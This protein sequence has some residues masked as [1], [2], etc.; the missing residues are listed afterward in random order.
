MPR[1]VCLL[2]L[3]L[4]VRLSA[5]AGGVAIVSFFPQLAVGD[6]RTLVTISVEVRDSTGRLVPDNTQVILSTTGGTISES[7]VTTRNGIARGTLLAP[8]RAGMVRVTASIPSE[9]TSVALDYEFVATAKEL[10]QLQDYVVVTSAGKLLYASQARLMLASGSGRQGRVKFRNVE[11]QADDLQYNVATSEVKA[12]NALLRVSGKEAEFPE[13]SYQLQRKTGYGLAKVE[14]LRP[15]WTGGWPGKFQI[16]RREALAIVEIN[17]SAYAE[18]KTAVSPRVFELEDVVGLGIDVRSQGATVW[19]NRQI[20]FQKAEITL[21]GKRIF[22][23]PLLKMGTLPNSPPLGEQVISVTNSNLALNYP[24]Y[25]SLKPDSM[26]MLRARSGFRSTTGTGATGGNFLD[27]EHRWNKG[28]QSDGVLLVRGLMRGDW[29]ATIQQFLRL[30]EKTTL[31]ALM[32]APAHASL[33]NNLQLSHQLPAASAYYNLSQSRTLRGVRFSTITHQWGLDQIP[34]VI[35]GSPFSFSLGLSGF[36]QDQRSS[37]GPS[38]SSHLGVRARFYSSSI[39]VTKT[40][41]ASTS[42]MVTHRLARHQTQGTAVQFNGSLYQPFRSGGLQLGYTF[43]DDPLSGF[44]VGRHSLYG[45]VNVAQGRTVAGLSGGKSLDA[46]RYNLTAHLGY[47]LG[48]AWQFSAMH[49]L[50]RYQSSYFGETSLVLSKSVQGI[51]LGVS[52]SSRTR[53]LG[54]EFLGAGL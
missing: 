15:R 30:S 31:N 10:N 14:R 1:F 3:T 4:A 50:D 41:S 49:S 52:Y 26:S 51:E 23:M 54:L 44:S 53:R 9:A 21:E 37:V 8:N 36:H 33:Y 22:R 2:L 38:S 46:R 7:I 24:Y 11:I 42:A 16:E 32:D 13:L 27:F 28:S 29:G 19:P 25:L 34:R 39:P 18:P 48:S 35:P 12:R 45:N 40:L 6:G 43:S 47:G 5:A 17:G 20:Y